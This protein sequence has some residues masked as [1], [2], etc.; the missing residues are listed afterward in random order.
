[1]DEPPYL[2]HSNR[3]LGLML[4]GTKPLAHFMEG[5][6]FWPD[7]VLRYF[8]M[9]DRHVAAGRLLRVDRYRPNIWPDIKVKRWHHVFFALPGEA[10]RIEAMWELNASDNEP[11]TEEHERREGL[12]YGYTQEQCEWWLEHGP[13]FRKEDNS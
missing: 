6:G 1:M 13:W 10:H 8:R 4:A 3:E 7:C 11:W 5:E 9:F 12:L 2:I